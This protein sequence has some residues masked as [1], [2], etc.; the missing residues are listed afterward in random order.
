MCLTSEWTSDGKLSLSAEFP[1][2]LLTKEQLVEYLTIV[3]FTASAQHAS[4]NFGQVR[5]HTDVSGIFCCKVKWTAKLISMFWLFTPVW[6][7]F[8]DPK[9]PPNHAETSSY[10]E[11]RGG[12]EVHSGESAWSRTLL[13]ASGSCVGPQSVSRKWGLK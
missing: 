5:L 8:M 7:V 11:G 9:F 4:V 12:F 1:K 13:L 6:L 3:I 2:S 10:K